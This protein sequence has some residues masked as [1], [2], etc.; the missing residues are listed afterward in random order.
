MCIRDRLLD[1]EEV[2][3]WDFEKHLR[4]YIRRQKKYSLGANVLIEINVE[5]NFILA[6][7]QSLNLMRII[8]EALNN[9]RKYA[10][11]NRIEISIYMEGTSLNVT[12]ADNGKGMHLDQELEKGN[13]LKN[14]EF[15][16]KEIDADFKIDSKIEKGTTIS[17]KLQPKLENLP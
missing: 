11:A 17:L 5:N 10:E 8:Q 3:F 15:R 16:S 2:S 7:S 1:K 9:A 12:V 6:P 13:G 14:M 4:S